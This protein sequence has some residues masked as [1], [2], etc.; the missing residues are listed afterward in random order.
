MIYVPK[1]VWLNIAKDSW[2]TQSV[3]ENIPQKK[4]VED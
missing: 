4:K 1:H 3:R 2:V